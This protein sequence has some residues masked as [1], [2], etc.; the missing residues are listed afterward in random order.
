MPKPE[1]YAIIV[2]ES[3]YPA[4]AKLGLE[5]TG[6]FSFRVNHIDSQGKI[7]LMITKIDFEAGNM[8]DK[9]MSDMMGS[10][11][12]NEDDEDTDDI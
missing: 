3:E 12:S 8:A 4:L 10:K 9:A 2:S 7:T 5:G 11:E 1:D 6:D